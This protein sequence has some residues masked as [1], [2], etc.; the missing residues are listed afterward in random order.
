M[1]TNGLASIRPRDWNLLL[2]QNCQRSI[3]SDIVEQR[4]IAW[5]ETSIYPPTL[6]E[7]D[8]CVPIPDAR[9]YRILADGSL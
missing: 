8:I 3:A 4:N 6:I 9:I 1:E 5:T 7:L 2:I